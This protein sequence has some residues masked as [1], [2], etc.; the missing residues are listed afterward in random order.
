VPSASLIRV[1]D[2]S[3]QLGLFDLKPTG[4]GVRGTPSRAEWEACGVLLRRIEGAVQWWIGDWLNYG[5]KAYGEKYT[6]AEDLTELERGTL[7][8]YAYVASRIQTSLRNDDL[9]YHVHVAVAPLEPNQQRA[10]LARALAE[11]LTVGEV[12]AAIRLQRLETRAPSA[13]PGVFEVI[14]A[15]P[16]WTYDNSGFTQ[17]AAAQYPTLDVEAIATLPDRD[18]T[19]PKI[20]DDAVLFLWATSPLLPDA[21]RVLDAWRFAY[22]ASMVWE[23]DAAPGIGWWVRTRHELLLIAERGSLHPSITPD[24]I[25]RAANG[26]HSEKPDEVYRL[27]EA[28]YPQ[29]RRVEV[30]ARSARPGWAVWGNEV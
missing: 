27:I 23:K 22:K 30:F 17:S 10:M 18:P 28:M 14:C 4:L 21:L 16:P 5:E 2:R 29:F 7:K 26:R 20:A 12:R 9:P 24:S 1:G 25:V 15:D 8:N 6:E 13:L 11:Q 3:F 19:F